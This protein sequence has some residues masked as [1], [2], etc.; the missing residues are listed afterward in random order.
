MRLL[1]K[2]LLGAAALAIVYAALR[3]DATATGEAVTRSA[4]EAEPVLGY[5]GMDVDTVIPWLESANLDRATL[6]RIRRYERSH[7]AREAVL[8]TLDA[9][10]A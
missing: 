2:L 8:E 10:L 7:R 1:L 5:D 9:L 3:P 4:G 6:E